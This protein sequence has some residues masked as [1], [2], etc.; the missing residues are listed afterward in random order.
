MC[1]CTCWIHYV[2]LYVCVSAR[3]YLCACMCCCTC[4]YGH[5]GVRG[6]FHV[7][8]L[9]HHKP[10]IFWNILS[11]PWKSLYKLGWLTSEPGDSACLCLLSFS[12]E[13]YSTTPISKHGFW[14]LD[15]GPCACKAN[16]FLT[17]LSP[18]SHHPSS[19]DLKGSLKPWRLMISLLA[20]LFPMIQLL[21]HVSLYG[22]SFRYNSLN[23][24]LNIIFI[25]QWNRNRHD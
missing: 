24:E 15:W 1:L 20:T 2:F 21:K 10:F 9:R 16:T 11:L 14:E 8:F 17:E 23:H 13:V 19:Y 5:V 18:Q 3:V 6:Q 12:V 4:V 25:F 22:S 7:S